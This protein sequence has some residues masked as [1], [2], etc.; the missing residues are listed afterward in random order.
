[1]SC[2]LLQ[3]ATNQPRG[4]PGGYTYLSLAVRSGR[5]TKKVFVGRDGPE[6]EAKAGRGLVVVLTL[7]AA[8]GSETRAANMWVVCHIL[9]S[10]LRMRGRRGI[11]KA[12][13]VSQYPYVAPEVCRLVEQA[14]GLLTSA[15]VGSWPVGRQ[16]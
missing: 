6:R 4:G 11:E 16:G 1:M 3:A 9:K 2:I 8:R 15:Y 13:E 5:Q 10:L 7:V 14:P 12:R